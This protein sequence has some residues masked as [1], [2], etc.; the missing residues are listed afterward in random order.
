MFA[1]RAAWVDDATPEDALAYGLANGLTSL[2]APT[3]ELLGL[4]EPTA[5]G[6]PRE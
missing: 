3:R 1:L 6:A 5:E 2:E 4:A